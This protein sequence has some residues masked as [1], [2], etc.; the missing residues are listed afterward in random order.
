MLKVK[1]K[2]AFMAFKALQEQV[3]QDLSAVRF[4]VIEHIVLEFRAD[5]SAGERLSKNPGSRLGC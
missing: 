5:N 4:A 2:V 3:A 1:A